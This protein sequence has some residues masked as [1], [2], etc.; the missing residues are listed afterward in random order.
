MQ[1]H[2]TFENRFINRILPCGSFLVRNVVK[3]HEKTASRNI[4]WKDTTSDK[5]R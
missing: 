1:K 5:L 2:N 3:L 4:S